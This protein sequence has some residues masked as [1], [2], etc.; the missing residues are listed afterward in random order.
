MTETV[1]VV[2]G[3]RSQRHILSVMGANVLASKVDVAEAVNSG[4]PANSLWIA[5]HEVSAHWLAHALAN[6]SVPVRGRFLA[7]KEVPPELATLF[8]D[9][10]DKIALKPHSLLPVT[11]IL[12]I[13]LRNDRDE[14]CIGASIDRSAQAIICVRGDF[15]VISAPLTFFESTSGVIPDFNDFEVIDHGR[16]LRFGKYQATFSALLYERDI[17]YRR[18]LNRMREQSDRSFS[19]SMRRLRKQRGLRLSDFGALEKTVARIERG[20]VKH[21]RKKTLKRIAKLL[22]V[23]PEHLAEY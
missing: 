9:T 6:S 16:T 17:R 2:D 4:P 8:A 22:R 19:A 18:H 15:S 21:P 23:A 20:E 5:L 14:F 13:F 1:Y 7:M 10:F 12:T 11:E 3:T